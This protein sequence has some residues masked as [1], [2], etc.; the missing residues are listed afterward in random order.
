MDYMKKTELHVANAPDTITIEIPSG[1]P[2]PREIAGVAY[3][4]EEPIGTQPV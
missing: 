4:R 1:E 3:R 2:T